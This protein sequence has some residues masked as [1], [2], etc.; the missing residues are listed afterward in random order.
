MKHDNRILA[1]RRFTD[2]VRWYIKHGDATGAGIAARAAVNALP[3][4]FR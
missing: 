1:A 2:L 4:F 3:W